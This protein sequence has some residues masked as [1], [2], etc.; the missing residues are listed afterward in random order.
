M[1]EYNNLSTIFF[2][3][4]TGRLWFTVPCEPTFE[5]RLVL[6]RHPALVRL[7][8]PTGR[9]SAHYSQL[10]KINLGRNCKV[11]PGLSKAISTP[12]PQRKAF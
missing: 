12:L 11:R 5:D 6:H 3:V 10:G 7:M 2:Y 4:V 9:L 1:H 8:F